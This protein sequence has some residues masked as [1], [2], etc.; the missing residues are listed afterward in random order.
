MQGGSMDWKKE[1]EFQKGQII[2]MLPNREDF[3]L[4]G[5]SALG[6]GIF[7]GSYCLLWWASSFF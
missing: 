2:G 6:G 5:V 3:F 1:I 4:M 7:L